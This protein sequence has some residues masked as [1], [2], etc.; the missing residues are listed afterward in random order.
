MEQNSKNEE[1]KEQI[2]NLAD[3][4]GPSFELELSFTPEEKILKDE[5]T[6]QEEKVYNEKALPMKIVVTEEDKVDKQRTPP[7]AR[8]KLKYQR[9]VVTRRGLPPTVNTSTKKTESQVI[10][11][12]SQEQ[13][14]PEA[15][16]RGNVRKRGREPEQRRYN[17]RG[18][19]D[20]KPPFKGTP[21]IHEVAK[22][23]LPFTEYISLTTIKF[24]EEF[25]EFDY[26]PFKLNNA[27]WNFDSDSIFVDST[28]VNCSGKVPLPV[29]K[30]TYGHRDLV[31]DE[32]SNV[33][34]CWVKK[35]F[36][37]EVGE[38]D[39][40]FINTQSGLFMNIEQFRDMVFCQNNVGSEVCVL[41]MLDFVVRLTEYF[42]N[43]RCIL[44]M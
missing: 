34:D 37:E 6:K 11:I 41:F 43:Y 13:E 42:I 26:I 32:V 36:Q 25:N 22:I 23:Q 8:A 33:L 2:C 4:D 40:P 31:S 10:V 17:T 28:F 5:V 1:G 39:Y 44:G 29:Q 20:A 15:K 9:R 19:C 35:F 18:N 38:S 24:E 16:K 27:D 7:K 3:M 21:F 12:S 30:W 14:K